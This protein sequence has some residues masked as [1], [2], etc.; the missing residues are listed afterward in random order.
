[1]KKILAILLLIS[2]ITITVFGLTG[3]YTTNEYFYL[4]GYGEYGIDAFN[5]YEDYMQIADTQIEANRVASGDE[6]IQDVSG[7]MFSDN[8]EVFIDLEY[9]DSDGTVD[10]TVPVKDEDNMVSDSATF[11]CT[12]QSIKAYADTLHALQYLKT[13][14]DSFSEIQ[15]IISNK[16]LVNEEDVATI[17]ADWVNTANPWADNEVADDITIDLA[18]LATTF[19]ATDNESEAL[20]CPIVFVDGATGAQG[21]ETDGDFHYNPSTGTI[22]ATVHAGAGGGL[23]VLSSAYTVDNLFDAGLRNGVYSGLAVTDV[24]GLNISWTS[25]VAY[26]NGSIFA[27]NADASEDIANNATTYLYVLKDNATMQ[28]SVTEPTIGVV[29]E[30][31]LVCVLHTYATDIHEKFD[32][33]LMSG[34]LRYDIWNFLEHITPTACVSGCNVSIDTDA[35]L[36]NDF[37]VAT[38]TYYTDVLDLNTISSILYSSTATHNGTNVTAYYHSSSAWTS[39]DEAGI[40][41]TQWD[42]GT[43]KTNTA[44]NKWYTGWIY[45]E[46]GDTLVYVYPQTEHASEGAALDEAAQFPPY[47]EGIILPS[48]KFIFRHGESAFGARAYFIDIR[49]FFGYGSGATAQ[50][51]YQ[52]VTGDSGTT[53]ATASD[54]SIAI[55]GGGIATTAVTADTVTITATEVDSVVGA[56]TG[57]VKSDGVAAFSA[58]TIGIANDNLVEMDDADAAVD[59]Y[60]QL[61]ANG[62]VGRSYSEVR[63]DLG[64]VTGTNVQA[65]DNALTS[66]SGLTYVEDSFIKLTANDTYAVRTIAEVITDLALDSDNLSDVASIAML[67]E[68]EIVTG[69][70]DFTTDF[71]ITRVD[72]I[73]AYSPYITFQRIRD[74]DPTYDVSSGDYLGEFTFRGYHGAYVT[75]ARIFAIVDG[76]PGANDMPGRLEFLTTPDDSDTPVLRMA[77][78]NAGNIKMGDGAWTN[79]VN[80]TNAGILTF[81]GTANLEGVDATEFGYLNGIT[82]FGGS[83]ID[84]ADAGAVR[85][86]LGLVIGTNVLAEQTI[87]IAN[88]NLLEV[89]DADAADDDYA[90]FTANGLEGRSYAELMKDTN[91]IATVTAVHTMTVAE[92]GTVLVSCAATPYTITLPTA[93]G[94]AGLTYHFIKTDANYFLIT[95]DGD[96]TETLNYENSTSTPNLTYSRLNTLCAEATFVSDDA[97]WQVINEAIGQVPECFI[98]LGIDQE[99][100]TNTTFTLVNLNTE[101]YDIGNNFNVTT[102][103]FTAPISGM[104][105]IKGSIRW[106]GELTAD[107]LYYCS[108]KVDASYYHSVFHSN[109]NADDVFPFSY[110]IVDVSAAEEI[111]LYCYHNSGDN[112]PDIQGSTSTHLMIKLLSKD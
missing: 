91:P 100:I 4:P 31:A 28:E 105:Q 13:E 6:N 90:K 14:M 12:Q 93:V 85:T 63:T 33:P 95:I 40:S 92:A 16:T 2:L 36:A 27:V 60:C 30:F 83:I 82:S 73:A 61:T 99:N 77:I 108:A 66:I 109:A 87:G 64:L 20:N 49:P 79:Y 59:D 96:G 42:N 38:G 50:M 107:K 37:K 71:S 51:I 76:T 86:T 78:D 74:G 68:N 102:H 22:T 34:A 55:V 7:G 110:H 32:F 57:I 9:Q 19:T 15:A 72:D 10:A 75:G 41:F 89:D 67:D 35:T 25:G 97:N 8:T 46:D 44:A 48:A 70:W 39:G 21:A 62:I 88:D 111:A 5:E 23:T 43:Q 106:Q 104:Y 52:T 17:D 26:V 18:T 80:V 11:L 112:A 29:G 3:T 53:T 101:N 84:D 54:D 81:E 47:H 1:M 65:F 58:A 69:I 103:I 45:V 94:N 24:S 98:S 56:V